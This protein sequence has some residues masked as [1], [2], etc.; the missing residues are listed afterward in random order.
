M[1]V[2]NKKDYVRRKIVYETLMIILGAILLASGF[3]GLAMGFIVNWM[4]FLLGI[5]MFL[6]GGIILINRLGEVAIWRAGLRGQMLVPKL[7]HSLSDD[8]VLINNVSLNGRNCDIDHV[9]V[10]SKCLFAIE[11]KNYNGEIFGQGDEWGYIKRGRAGGF[12][13]GHIGN[14]ARQIKRSVWELK[15]TMDDELTRFGLDPTGLWIEPI[16][17]FTNPNTVLKIT[18]SPVTAIML[19]ELQSFVERFEPKTPIGKEMA[20]AI[21]SILKDEK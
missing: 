14:P 12:Y 2:I 15:Q 19:S 18:D 17:A 21:I 9:I 1:Q 13:R 7:L 5:I 16:V 3:L 6:L 11:S 20:T 4:F 8:Y 10:S